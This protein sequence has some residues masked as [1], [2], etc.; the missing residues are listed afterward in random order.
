MGNKK[1]DVLIVGGG[2]SGL[3]LGYFLKK[4]RPDLTLKILEKRTH[5]THDRHW[6]FWLNKKENFEFSDL[7]QKTY[8]TWQVND[9]NIS[10]DMYNYAVINSGKFYASMTQTLK[11]HI[12]FSAEPQDIRKDKVI[13]NSGET[14]WAEKVFSSIPEKHPTVKSGLWQKFY[15]WHVQTENPVF[16]AEKAVIM[17]FF[18]R[19]SSSNYADAFGFNYIL[20]FSN[21]EALIEPTVFSTTGAENKSYFENARD[22]YLKNMGAGNVNIRH[23]ESASLPMAV[24]PAMKNPDGATPIGAAGGWLRPSTGYSFVTAVK[25]AEKIARSPT[26]DSPVPY[27]KPLLTMDRIFLSIAHNRPARMPSLFSSWFAAPQQDSFIKFLQ[28]DSLS[29][30]DMLKVIYHTP[31]KKIFLAE[32]LKLPRS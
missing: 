11:E 15:G 31:Y 7:L 22:D 14:L 13:M 19:Q 23:Q 6:A 9:K 20:P 29:V 4:H 2:L 16:T 25:L 27:S 17:D 30:V 12:V 24:M 21:H 18:S 3:L 5:Y 10:S 26:L 1:F 28:N 8:G 32:L